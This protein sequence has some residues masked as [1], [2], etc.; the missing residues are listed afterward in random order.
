MPK[1]RFC[2]IKG[3]L[4]LLKHRWVVVEVLAFDLFHVERIGE[5]GNWWSFKTPCPITRILSPVDS[6]QAPNA[7][8]QDH[9][10]IL[11]VKVK[12]VET[13]QFHSQVRSG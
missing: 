9:E 7:N 12:I 2:K 3:L 11:D 10:L 8:I 5:I 1:K 13:C 6:R 4:L